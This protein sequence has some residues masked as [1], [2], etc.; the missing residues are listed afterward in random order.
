MKTFSRISNCAAYLPIQ[1]IS[2]S[3]IHNC[4]A[5]VTSARLLENYTYSSYLQLY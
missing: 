4:P 2:V 3:D 1:L 5:Y